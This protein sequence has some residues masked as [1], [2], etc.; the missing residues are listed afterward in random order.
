MTAKLTEAIAYLRSQTQ[1]NEVIERFGDRYKGMVINSID[2]AIL[3]LE[4]ARLVCEADNEITA[5][6]LAT[7]R[8]GAWIL[9]SEYA[10]KERA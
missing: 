8:T 7:A 3:I 9:K 5:E 10:E 4:D 1:T 2:E 6:E